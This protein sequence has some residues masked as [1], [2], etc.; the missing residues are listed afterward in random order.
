MRPK[1]EWLNQLVLNSIDGKLVDVESTSASIM[2]ANI[3]LYKNVVI[4]V[5]GKRASILN[6][7]LETRRNR[8]T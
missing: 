5:I 4:A 3:L 1:E 7:R 8:I 6:I 2:Q